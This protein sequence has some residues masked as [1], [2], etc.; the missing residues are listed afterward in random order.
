MARGGRERARGGHNS[1]RVWLRPRPRTTPQEELALRCTHSPTCQ[2]WEHSA[3]CLRM[4]TT[5]RLAWAL[6]VGDLLG[7]PEVDADFAGLTSQALLGVSW[8][9]FGFGKRSCSRGDAPMGEEQ[10]RRVGYGERAGVGHPHASLGALCL[11]LI[12]SACEL[13]LKPVLLVNTA[14][15]GIHP[16]K[17]AHLSSQGEGHS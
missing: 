15:L 8:E 9:E 11:P 13:A 7:A 1:P 3:S 16:A 5:H 4:V 6:L 17:G 12:Q 14:T 2:S 10:R